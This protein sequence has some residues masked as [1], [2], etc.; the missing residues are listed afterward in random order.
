MADVRNCLWCGKIF[1]YVSGPVICPACRKKDEEDFKKIKQ[2]L[3]D[4]P[5]ASIS[6]ISSN[7]EI[8]VKR[9]KEYLRQGRLE[10]INNDNNIY[11]ECQICGK[12]IKS[13]K[14]CEDCE[15]K[16]QMRFK[17]TADNIR[18]KSQTENKSNKSEFKEWEIL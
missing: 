11:L 15:R 3:Y 17:N 4:Y 14:Y 8:S 6:Q 2:Y 12:P 7:L 18:N 9:I 5:R 16:L 1:N 13:G 10:I